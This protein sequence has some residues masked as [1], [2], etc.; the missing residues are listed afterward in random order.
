MCGNWNVRQAVSQQ[1]FRVTT[2]CIITCFQ[3][4][5][6]L[7]RRVVHHAVLAFSP[8]R[9]KPLP[10]ASTCPTRAPP[11]ACPR[12]RDKFIH[13][14]QINDVT[15][16]IINLCGRLPGRKFPSSWPPVVIQIILSSEAIFI[17]VFVRSDVRK[18][19]FKVVLFNITMP[20]RKR[21]DYCCAEARRKK[22][23][24]QKSREVRNLDACC[25]TGR[26]TLERAAFC[27]NTQYDYDSVW[28]CLSPLSVNRRHVC[29]MPALPGAKK[30]VAETL[31]SVA[32][33][34]RLLCCHCLRPQNLCCHFWQESTKVRQIFWWRHSATLENVVRIR[35]GC[36]HL[37]FKARF[38][39]LLDRYCR[40]VSFF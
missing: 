6:T 35:T 23:K 18:N 31:G 16:K 15:I 30:F 39:T 40:T 34:V 21:T 28:L 4:F 32:I 38:T 10:Q 36:R 5:S 3:S 26:P 19:K 8:C 1:V 27:C 13:H 7:F 25:T 11:V 12:K 22:V 20:K 14:K 9:N 24:Y 2:F 29:E 33:A 17:F 37:E